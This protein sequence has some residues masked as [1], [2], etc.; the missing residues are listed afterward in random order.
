MLLEII[1][2]LEKTYESLEIS[3]PDNHYVIIEV[4]SR[5]KN[6]CK[7]FFFEEINFLDFL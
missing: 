3:K 2:H 5:D 7:G 4:L 1:K 6:I